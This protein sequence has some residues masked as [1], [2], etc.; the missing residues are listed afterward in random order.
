MNT[1]DC[2]YTAIKKNDISYVRDN[3]K[4]DFIL[5]KS[6]DYYIHEI[7]KYAS[8]EMIKIIIEKCVVVT[9]LYFMISFLTIRAN[10]NFIIFKRILHDYVD[11]FD[12][13][14]KI[15]YLIIEVLKKEE[16]Y[17]KK[18]LKIIFSYNHIH[19]F[20]SDKYYTHPD[21]ISFI[22]KNK[23]KYIQNIFEEP[24]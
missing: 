17:K 21:I 14:T 10:N 22:R 19:N 9:H 12:S 8:Y 1:N 2:I 23:I 7:I 13:N 24:T 16:K 4:S 3:L 15:E 11:L 20:I 6:N 5:F 18:Y